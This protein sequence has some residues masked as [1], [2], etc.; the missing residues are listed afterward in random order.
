[1]RNK[2]I[3]FIFIIILGLIAIFE[4]MFID[5]FY[6]RIFIWDTNLTFVSKPD[7][8]KALQANFKNRTT[9]K[10]TFNYKNQDYII[11][12]ATASAKINYQKTID[13]AFNIGREGNFL[14]SLKNQLQTI[15]YGVTLNP[16]IDLN[17]DPQLSVI[18][19]AVFKMPKNPNLIFNE[20]DSPKNL[21]IEIQDGT[22]GQELDKEK[23]L[24][25]INQYVASGKTVES[26][27][28]KEIPPEIETQKISDFVK[29]LAQ[30]IDQPVIE[31]QFNF[32]E[33]TKRVTE[34]K[35]AQEGKTL[36]QE[37]TK[38]LIRLALKGERSKAITLPSEITNP[39]VT[40]DR[41]NNLGIK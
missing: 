19:K 6:P 32:N 16:E 9:K 22:S 15:V 26:L 7:A 1:M 25:L 31:P 5:K 4:L 27:P 40:T 41:V 35:S 34:F 21:S 33:N 36:D 10:L 38:Q 11:D 30:K 20:F 14:D 3:L 13:S 37:K 28:V 12:L 8:M 29:E 24:L 23:L 39:K 17:I 18:E 2:N